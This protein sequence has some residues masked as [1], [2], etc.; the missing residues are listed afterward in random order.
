MV[1]SGHWNVRHRPLFII[2][3]GR[4]TLCDVTCIKALGLVVSDKKM[5]LFSLYKPT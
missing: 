5:L 4:V 3:L 2:S 1:T